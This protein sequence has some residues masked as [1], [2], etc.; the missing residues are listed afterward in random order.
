[1]QTRE[2]TSFETGMTVKST[3]YLRLGNREV[4][5]KTLPASTGS[6]AFERRKHLHLWP[7]RSGD[8][9]DGD[10][11]QWLR[12][13]VLLKDFRQLIFYLGCH[14]TCTPSHSHVRFAQPAR[15]AGWSVAVR[16]FCLNV[17]VM[18]TPSRAVQTNE[19]SSNDEVRR[20]A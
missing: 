5:F 19:S 2:C 17:L 6:Q 7:L 15:A 10:L 20:Q 4:R 1:M 18:T 16:H 11:R 14:H 3:T 9:A 13:A 12:L 8:I